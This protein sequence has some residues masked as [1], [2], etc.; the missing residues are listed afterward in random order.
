[1]IST[2]NCLHSYGNHQTG[3]QDAD[4]SDE[5]G[6]NSSERGLHDNIAVAY[7]KSCDKGKIEGISKR[8]FLNQSDGDGADY[9]K[10]ELRKKIALRSQVRR[11]KLARK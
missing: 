9:H 6:D 2:S 7:S 3:K 4:K 1:M 10:K 11:K 5:E 8:Y